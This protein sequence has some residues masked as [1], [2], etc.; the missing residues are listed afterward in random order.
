[1]IVLI[2][3]VTF[4][5]FLLFGGIAISG[6]YSVTRGS[7]KTMPDGTKKKEGQLLR[8]WYL[9]WYREARVR[10]YP[11]KQWVV[12]KKKYQYVGDELTKIVAT[13]QNT[14]F[15]FGIANYLS[16]RIVVASHPDQRT[17]NMVANSLNIA[18]IMEKGQEGIEVKF[19]M[20][21][22]EYVFPWWLRKM[23]AGCI[24]C[25]SSWLGSIIF[26]TGYGIAHNQLAINSNL[27]VILTWIA[28]CFSLAFISPYL[29]K[30]VS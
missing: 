11:S 20:E 14:A 5:L 24:T 27:L 7:I 10:S 9:F 1:M 16:D 25:H 15:K 21:E 2:Y 18:V 22:T 30:K 6:F 17:L 19:Y 4:F 28:Y 8:D 29:Y 12:R 13:W 3:L 26:W 23:M